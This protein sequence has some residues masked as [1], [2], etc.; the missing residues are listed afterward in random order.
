ML[1]KKIKK[2]INVCQL[3][4]SISVSVANQV[5]RTSEYTSGII[6]RQAVDYQSSETTRAKFYSSKTRTFI[7]ATL[8]GLSHTFQALNSDKKQNINHTFLFSNLK[9]GRYHRQFQLL[10]VQ[11]LH[12]LTKSHYVSAPGKRFHR[13]AVVQAVLKLDYVLKQQ[14]HS[15]VESDSH[16]IVA[17]PA[18]ADRDVS[19]HI[20]CDVRKQGVI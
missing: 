10:Q 3:H 12:H 6:H 8:A 4:N 16:R 11:V 5:P 2:K 14:L 7:S 20:H 9:V 13:I 17:V 15:D 19:L 18:C 1:K